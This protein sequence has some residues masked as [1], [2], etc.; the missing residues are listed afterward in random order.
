MPSP[1]DEQARRKVIQQWF[2]GLPRDTIA[3]DNNIGAGTVSS[4]IANYKV[5]LE[6]L[7]FDSIRQISIEARQHGLNLSDLASH[8]RLYNYFRK[9]GTNEDEIETFI[10][11]VHSSDISPEKVIECVNQ[12][13]E[14]AK[15]ESIPLEDVPNYIGE[16]L[17]EKKKI[18]QE[19][20]EA[21]YIL[22]D[23]NANI[24]AIDEHIQLNEELNEHNLSFQDIDE[25][26]N[27]LLNAKE[28]GF[29]AKKI[30][31]K[32][33]N[34]Q[35]LEWKEKQLKDKCNKLSKRISK[36][37]DIV[38]L[39]EDIA[40]LQ[41]GIDELIALKVGVKAAAKLYNLHPLAATL[42]LINDIKTYNKIDGLKKE[43]S[44]LYFQK[45]TLTEAC[46]HQTQAL[47]NL[48]K[49]QSYG[50]TEDKR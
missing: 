48:A 33:Y 29:D 24:E 21:N 1:I 7:D 25:L 44:A 28:Y 3:A 23:K 18:D 50:I 20:K 5:G 40:A 13:H 34:I 32:L 39:T 45:Y 38:P 47:I 22:R 43:L 9:L 2:S 26:L 49:I 30:A 12:I 27:L 37:K 4:I 11:N 36:Y 42:Q 8:F 41:I 19:I 35:E 17:E 14:I 31:S 15:E 10:T 16:K 46:S 6:E